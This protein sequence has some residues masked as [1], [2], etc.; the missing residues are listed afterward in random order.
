MG[1]EPLETMDSGKQT[2]G[3]RGDG[4]EGWMSPVMDI[5]EDT[6]CMEHWVL[7]TNNELWNTT[8]KPNDVFYGD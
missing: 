6:Y 5:K 8:S 3:F 4:V 1:D 2:E 7:L